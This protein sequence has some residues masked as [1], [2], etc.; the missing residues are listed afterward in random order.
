[1]K[2][3]FKHLKDLRTQPVKFESNHPYRLGYMRLNILD[4]SIS[5][6]KSEVTVF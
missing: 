2:L 4:K 3:G 1:M 6:I 5:Q